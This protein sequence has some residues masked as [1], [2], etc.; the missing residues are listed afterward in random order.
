MTAKT[1]ADAKTELIKGLNV[2]ATP[3]PSTMQFTLNTRS[4]STDI[5]I[6]TVTDVMGRVVEKRSNVAANTS[7]QFGSKYQPGIYFVEVQ[8]GSE[9]K[10]IKLVKQ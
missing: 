9:R 7:L 6:I 4:N 1:K 2:N 3:N 10:I 5:L 8:Q